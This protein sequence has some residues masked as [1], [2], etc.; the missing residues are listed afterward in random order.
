MPRV[1]LDLNEAADLQKV[2]GQWRVGQG[3]V[4]GEPNEGLKAQILNSPAR[5]ADYDDSGWEVCV[6]IRKSRSVGFTFA[7]YR[8]SV[9]IPV[10]T[11]GVLLADSRVYFETNVDNYGEVWI[12]GKINRATGVIAGINA[13]HR[14]EVSA[15]A[16]PG[17]KHVIACLVANGPIA[18]PVGGIFMRYAT[19]AFES[20]D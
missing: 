7:W 9:E 5:L 15:K 1:A 14:V 12:D 18:E 6:N 3:L 8:T 11:D 16:V 20:R 17:A 13:Q 2:K 10:E 4:P 19:L